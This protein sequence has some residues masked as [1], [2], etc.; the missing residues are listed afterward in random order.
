MLVHYRSPGRAVNEVVVQSGVKGKGAEREVIA[1]ALD[2]NA[3]S[4]D[5]AGVMARLAREIGVRSPETLIILPPLL[6]NIMALPELDRA[7]SLSKAVRRAGRGRVSR[8]L[9]VWFTY[10]HAH[11]QRRRWLVMH[12]RVH[13]AL[14]QHIGGLARDT[15]CALVGGT[16][17]LSHPR[18]HWEAWPDHGELFHTAWSFGPDGEPYDVIRQPRC[19]L[20]VLDDAELD[21]NESLE[22][23]PLHTGLLDVAPLWEAEVPDTPL[24]WLP[25]VRPEEEG[26]E[27]LEGLMARAPTSRALV[28]SALCGHLGGPLTGE[29][30]ISLRAGDGGGKTERAQVPTAERPATWV[31]ASF[32]VPQDYAT[33]EP[34]GAP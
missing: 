21:G 25:Q 14:R 23:R 11:R 7:A 17:V 30:S 28:V 6:A 18:T 4:K 32:E 24:A 13:S 9:G 12:D 33:Q 31:S 5:P 22:I 29:A 10:P 34:T 27:A 20:S 15:N 1:V 3:V 8:R 19:R 16:V 2:V 26:V